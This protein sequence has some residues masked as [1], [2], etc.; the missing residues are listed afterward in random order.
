MLIFNTRNAVLVA[1]GQVGI[2]V[3]GVL[4]AGLSYKWWTAG[5]AMIPLT[6]SFLVN[7]GIVLFGLPIVWVATV[8]RVGQMPAVSDETKGLAFLSGF[9]ILLALLVLV[10]HGVFTPWL[11]CH[12][13][14]LITPEG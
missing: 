1:L 3:M 5:S 12:M 10:V 11:S 6:T 2:I 14:E 7:Y 8:V 13:G 9:I 4:A